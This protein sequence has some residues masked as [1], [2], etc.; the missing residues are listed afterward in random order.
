MMNSTSKMEWNENDNDY[1]EMLPEEAETLF[2]N[3]AVL[4]V[5]NLPIGSVF[6]IDMK[7]YQIAENFRGLKMI[8]PGV[9]FIHYSAVSKDGSTAPRTGFF[10]YFKK[11]EIIIKKW[12]NSDEGTYVYV[13][14]DYKLI[15]LYNFTLLLFSFLF[16]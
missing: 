16:S 12:D 5:I 11:G 14:L 8:P 2:L 10:H 7:V 4:I 3:G 13:F 6:G 9:H 1:M 15:S